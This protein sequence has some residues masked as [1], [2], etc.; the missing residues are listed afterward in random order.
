MKTSVPFSILALVLS[1]A[2][3]ADEVCNFIQGK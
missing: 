2:L 1:P 3:R